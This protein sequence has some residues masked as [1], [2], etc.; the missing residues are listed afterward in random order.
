ML[1]PD[2]IEYP[3]EY[4]VTTETAASTARNTTTRWRASTTTGPTV[5]RPSPRPR[6]WWC[7]ARATR[8]STAVHAPA[9]PPAGPGAGRGD[10]RHHRHVR[11]LDTRPDMPITWGDDVL[12]VLMGTLPEDDLVRHMAERRRAGGDE[13]RAQPAKVRRALERAGRLDAGLAGGT[14]HD[15]GPARGAAGRGRGRPTAPISRS[16]WCMARAA[17]RR[18][19]NDAAGSADRRALGPGCRGAGRRREVH[20]AALGRGDGCGRLHSLC[21]PRRAARRA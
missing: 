15:A 19:R 8:S 11:L 6:M 4:P 20:A 21:R 5:W 13:D 18:C 2:V 17:A 3:M 12:T 7:C 9:F 14:R 10:P 1:P 16:C